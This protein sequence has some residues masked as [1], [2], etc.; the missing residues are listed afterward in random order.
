MKGTEIMTICLT[1]IVRARVPHGGRALCLNL[2]CLTTELLWLA[3]CDRAWALWVGPHLVGILAASSVGWS[4]SP[5]TVPPG[6]ALD[7]ETALR[8][9]ARAVEARELEHRIQTATESGNV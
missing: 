1:D 4:W 9:M 7:R 3:P 2:D 8:R 6:E 5:G